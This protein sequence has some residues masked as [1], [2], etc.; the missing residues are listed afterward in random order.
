[1]ATRSFSRVES[2][3]AILSQ[4][5]L[6]DFA[7]LRRHLHPVELTV[8]QVLYEPKQPI[9]YAYF[10]ESGMVSVVAQMADGNSIEVGTIGREGM[11]G[12]ILLMD[13]TR[14][15]HRCFIQVAGHA[16]RIDAEAF[17]QQAERHPT[18]K[19]LILRYE[20]S[21]IDQSMQGIACNGLHNVEQR[22]CR[23]LLTAQ[24]RS[25]SNDIALT[26]ELLSLMLGVR[27]ASVSDVLGPLDAAGL[28][29]S[30]RGHITILNREGLE[31]GACECYRAIADQQRR[32]FDN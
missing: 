27:R 24:D 18:L 14:A 21:L 28:I 13:T 22:C 3:N 7:D 16:Q 20:A 30:T 19:N 5:S 17:K 4:L 10:P 9:P 29:S 11:L 23:W 12:G 26:H 6:N 8:R 31:K 32:L 1:M 25:E 15:S 2:K